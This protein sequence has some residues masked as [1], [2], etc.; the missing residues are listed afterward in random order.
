MIN[1]KRIKFKLLRFEYNIFN[2]KKMSD[3]S[4]NDKLYNNELEKLDQFNTSID[5]NNNIEHINNMNINRTVLSLKKDIYN[6]KEK[7]KKLENEKNSHLIKISELSKTHILLMEATENN[8]RLTDEVKTKQEIIE[9]L[10]SEIIKAAK[11]KKEEQRLMENKFNNQLIYYKRFYDAGIA[12]ENASSSILKL[13]ET[14]HNYIKKLENKIE[15]D[16]DNYEQKIKKL[17]LD[18]E[19]RYC[20]LKKQMM[21]FLKNSQ[22]NM[23]KN[24]EENIELNSKL[25]IL[26]K[27]QML[28]E[29]ENQSHQIEELLKD[30]DKKDKEIYLL[31]QE[32]IVH[33]KVEELIKSKNRKYMNIINKLD[34]KYNHLEDTEE[35]NIKNQ[36]P[37]FNSETNIKSYKQYKSNTIS[38]AQSVKL[39]ENPQN[40]SG[41][42]LKSLKDIRSKE[43][44]NKIIFNNLLKEIIILFNTTLDKIIREKE[45]TEI[46][47]KNLFSENFNFKSLNDEQK[48]ELLIEVMKKIFSLLNINKQK[49]NELLEIKNKID[50][51]NVYYNKKNTLYLCKSENRNINKSILSDKIKNNKLMNMEIYKK[52]D[53]DYLKIKNKEGKGYNKKLYEK[54]IKY[55]NNK[56]LKS[57]RGKSPFVK[58]MFILKRN[59]NEDI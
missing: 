12:K 14:Q 43:E 56:L 9:K 27:N 29:L 40:L 57:F 6:L 33:K 2:I 22:K 41:K 39:Y 44:Y 42:Y 16:K 52:N 45:I 55:N 59:N 35:V 18:H 5:N 34:M 13:N 50:S 20:K 23:A 10:Q 4:K 11:E 36:K 8:K 1:Y 58:Q 26:Y 24:N 47:S 54:I 28:N 32:L 21:E 49:D 53:K 46:Y 15:E 7:I 31:K 25:T 30:N 51:I 37:I 19:N 48:C 3:L 17:E 38:R